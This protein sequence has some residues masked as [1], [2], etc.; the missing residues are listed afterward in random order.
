MA[1][2]LIDMACLSSVAWAAGASMSAL[3]TLREDPIAAALGLH[4]SSQS[5]LAL[6]RLPWNHCGAHESPAY[7]SAAVPLHT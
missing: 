5:R 1:G 2:G 3:V 4:A 7:Y 6:L